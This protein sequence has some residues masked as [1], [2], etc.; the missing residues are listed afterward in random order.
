[1]KIFLL[2][3][4]VWLFAAASTHGQDLRRK[5][6]ERVKEP[7]AKPETPPPGKVEAPAPGAAPKFRETGGKTGG[8]E[9]VALDALTGETLPGATVLVTETGAGTH[10]LLDGKFRISGLEPGAYNVVASFVGYLPVTFKINVFEGGT[11]DVGELRLESDAI[12]IE[13]IKVIANYAVD[14]V[15]PVAT[16]LVNSVR[17]AETY[18][19]AEEFPSATKFSPGVY[20]SRVGGGFGDS[21]INVR[22]FEQE[23]LAV[24]INGIPINDI[25]FGKVYWSNWAGL[26]EVTRLVQVQR[27][28]GVS[29]MAINSVGGTMNIIT[30]TTDV[31]KGGSLS[32]E[33]TNNFTRRTAFINNIANRMSLMLST[34][35]MRGGWA[36]TAQASR[37]WGP[38]YIEGTFV[39]YWSYFASVSKEF[40][41]KHLLVLTGLGAPQSHGEN[42]IPSAPATIEK[43]GRRYGANW[44]YLDGQRVS[45]FNFYHKPQFALNH[46][47]YLNPG[48]TQLSTSVYFSPGTGGGNF[49]PFGIRNNQGL[50]DFEAMRAVNQSQTV[51][52]VNPAG[53]TLATGFQANFYTVDF[54]L[55]QYWVGAISNLTHRVGKLN[56]MFGVDLRHYRGRQFFALNNML[57]A[58]FG[59]DFSDVRNPFRVV[60]RGDKIWQ[61]KIGIVT[62]AGAFGQAEYDW[63]TGSAFVST[64]FISNHYR[65][66]DFFR[67]QE[68][69]GD[70]SPVVFIPAYS[71]KGGVNQNFGKYFNAYF[72]GGY[73]TRAP[74]FGNVFPFNN[75]KTENIT[76][77]KIASAELGVSF[78]N[79]WLRLGINGYYT[80]F[81][82]K[83]INL[84]RGVD[85]EGRE[86]SALINGLRAEHRGIEAE[87]QLQP[88]KWVTLEGFLSF[89]DWRWTTDVTAYVSDFSRTRLDTVNIYAKD[90]RK[91]NAPQTSAGMGVMFRPVNDLFFGANYYHYARFY[92][93]FL[94][95]AR[96]DA[97]LSQ[98][99]RP[100]VSLLPSYGITDLHAGY[101]LKFRGYNIQ[102]TAHVYNLFDKFYHAEG[103]EVIEADGSI[104]LRVF[105]G[106]GQNWSVGAK[107]MW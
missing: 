13:E 90:L 77:E 74:F 23:N 19:V 95:T 80:R 33:T 103:Q 20:V 58:D 25:E 28:M 73:F 64:A 37:T 14:R 61:H 9:G 4:A 57:G 98:Y 104:G 93:D 46:Y 89:G 44:G 66:L 85:A 70:V 92:A 81:A 43:F 99:G 48:K 102:F 35:R 2:S 78:K 62:W 15:T 76:N 11:T 72:N 38:G 83:T 106:F 41:G 51:S 6:A 45:G 96:G 68:G 1:M 50:W 71:V 101:T 75:E 10:T 40:G 39:N 107:L 60:R 88:A 3:M 24:M 21:R 29:K 17:I 12:G 97:F 65:R 63:K 18:S 94:V 49:I 16:S 105:Q 86:L 42:G 26:S 54:R 59:V 84:E 100:Q 87:L 30:K 53:D 56:L 7:K 22:G 47:W 67:Y 31:E 52:A 8:V 5:G 27:G 34:G 82:D 36:V 32:F 79:T 91:G 69:I 55:D